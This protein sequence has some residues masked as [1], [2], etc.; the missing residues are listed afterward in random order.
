[1]RTFYCKG[2]QKLEQV[3]DTRKVNIFNCTNI[4]IDGIEY[5]ALYLHARPDGKVEAIPGGKA[6]IMWNL[7]GRY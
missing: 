5:K 2:C 1:M 7:G 3:P 4:T 6:I